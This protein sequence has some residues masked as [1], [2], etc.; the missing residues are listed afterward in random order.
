MD[1]HVPENGK[2]DIP[3]NAFWNTIIF[4]YEGSAVYNGGKD[5]HNVG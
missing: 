3:M 2:F 1:I 4:V 5:N